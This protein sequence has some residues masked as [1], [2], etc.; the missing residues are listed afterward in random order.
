[1][2]MVIPFASRQSAFTVYK[3]IVVPLPQ[4]EEDIAI[5]WKV[6]SEY[7]AVSQ[8]LWETSLVT[9]DQFEKCIG[10]RE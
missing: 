7:L 10:S 6:E 5:K 4:I 2:T 9:R 3:A 8:D 1:M